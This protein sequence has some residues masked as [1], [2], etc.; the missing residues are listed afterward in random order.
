MA[1]SSKELA[2]ELYNFFDKEISPIIIKEDHDDEMLRHIS[3]KFNAKFSTKYRYVA[4]RYGATIRVSVNYAPLGIVFFMAAT[5][6]G[7]TPHRFE[8]PCYWGKLK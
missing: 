8:D 4:K 3:T 2:Q 7:H 6:E 1:T 5:R